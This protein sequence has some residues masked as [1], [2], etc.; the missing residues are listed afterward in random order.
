MKRLF[1]ILA[2]VALLSVAG[3]AA[4]VC[5]GAQ[6]VLA[7][8]FSCEFGGLLFSNF[9]AA[10][11]G[12]VPNPTMLLVSASLAGGDVTLN[13]NPNLSASNGGYV[14]IWFW[15]QVDGAVNAIDLAVGNSGATI[16]ETACLTGPIVGGA[17]PGGI[18]NQLATL[19]LT[20]GNSGRASFPGDAFVTPVYVFKNIKVQAPA[21][22]TA[23]FSA[24]SQS[25]G[26]PEP[27][28]MVLFG[29][30]LFALGLVRRFRRS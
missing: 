20:S 7:V 9:A 21:N 18:G 22:G 10:N 3:Y 30:G 4:P 26:V 11:A 28:T 12:N 15:F 8:N 17:C 1:L 24:F 5:G 19:T 25:F 14:D 16:T 13:F 23:E 27:V 29:S 6:D 2:A